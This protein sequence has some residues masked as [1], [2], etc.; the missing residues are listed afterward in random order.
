MQ[1]PGFTRALVRKGD[2]ATNLERGS[3]FCMGLVADAASEGARHL[4]KLCVEEQQRPRLLP[5]CREGARH[6][7]KI[8]VEEQSENVHADGP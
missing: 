3:R 8:C 4:F 1:Q 6:L 7:L 2:E 5:P